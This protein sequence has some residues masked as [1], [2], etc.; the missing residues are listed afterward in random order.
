MLSG[1]IGIEPLESDS[2]EYTQL[3]DTYK[4]SDS[5]FPSYPIPIAFNAPEASPL[6]KFSNQPRQQLEV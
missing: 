4:V 1:K 3:S 6:A 5:F 2:Y